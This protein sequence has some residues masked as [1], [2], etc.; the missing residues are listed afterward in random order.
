MNLKDYSDR[1]I[2]MPIGAGNEKLEECYQYAQSDISRRHT[3][4]WEGSYDGTDSVGDLFAFR[5]GEDIEVFRVIRIHGTEMRE[6]HWNPVEK[7]KG[8]EDRTV[9]EFGDPLGTISWDE[10]LDQ[11]GHKGNTPKQAGRRFKINERE[12]CPSE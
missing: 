11:L 6:S 3:A 9:V 2:V 5:R 7:T 8:G 12:T 1:I 10:L 4:L